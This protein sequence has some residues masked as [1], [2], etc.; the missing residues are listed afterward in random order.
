MTRKAMMA[1]AVMVLAAVLTVPGTARASRAL[2]LVVVIDDSGSMRKTDPDNIRL[3]A[4]KLL[5]RLLGPEDAVGLVVFDERAVAPVAVTP[6][7]RGAPDAFDRHIDALRADGRFTDIQAGL[8][9]AYALLAALPG[10]PERTRG[11]LLMTDGKID[12][13]DAERDAASRDTVLGSLAE[14]L[15]AQE[16]SVYGLAFTDESDVDLI[17]AVSRRTGGI[18]AL[19]R[20]PE[21]LEDVFLSFFDRLKLPDTVP[22]YENRFVLDSRVEEATVIA[23]K[24]GPEVKVGLLG[25]DGGELPE[26]AFVRFSGNQYDL[27][28]I[29]KP[30]PGE[31]TI[32]YSS[33]ENN[34]VV[35]LTDLQIGYEPN[36]KR[37][38]VGAT[39]DVDIQLRDGDKIVEDPAALQEVV[40]TV[41]IV[42]SEGNGKGKHQLFLADK[43]GPGIW[44]DRLAFDRPGDYRVRIDL[45]ALTFKRRLEI[46]VHIDELWFTARIDRKKDTLVAV[47]EEALPH[48]EV[49]L[50]AAEG[51]L[52]VHGT[53]TL[54]P[55][56]NNTFSAHYEGALP[57]T[58]DLTVALKLPGPGRPVGLRF[59]GLVIGGSGGGAVEAGWGRTIAVFA[60]VNLV[61]ALG[62]GAVFR[63]RKRRRGRAEEEGPEIE[64]EQE[65][66][67]D[68]SEQGLS[69]E[70]AETSA[71][72]ST[73]ESVG[74]GPAEQEQ[75]PDDEPV[76]LERAEENDSADE[77]DEPD[78]S[79][80]KEIPIEE[81][82]PVREAS[83]APDTQTVE[84]TADEDAE[85]LD[86]TIEALLSG[87]DDGDEGNEEPGPGSA[88]ET[89]PSID[90]DIDSI[91]DE[92][93]GENTGDGD[94]SATTVEKKAPMP[95]DP[96]S[97]N[98]LPGDTV[99]SPSGE[100][101]P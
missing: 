45:T 66:I 27:I 48:P 23:H 58:A 18:S 44:T 67:A 13:G 10:R 47:I 22:V 68:E 59:P 57:D 38:P 76:L 46:P 54:N 69:E 88:T 53:I 93:F 2:D 19:A 5:L 34:R 78:S 71:S 16:T 95:G 85:S 77:T 87:R 64:P 4:A 62:A 50:S 8:E 35:L 39:A 84:D 12:T 31:W 90:R 6:L 51:D 30:K 29:P 101:T 97:E 89:E 55:A 56:G 100:P 86:E 9:K 73:E 14:R 28:T 7:G 17:E 20:S 99:D 15:A 41:E 60:G 24:S 96:A 63:V 32:Q 1:M 79:E 37:L 21:E 26:K 40:T 33:G 91:V 25:P 65:V 3:T 42:D 70:T 81:D 43:N 11:V 94:T 80:L 74:N 36:I 61:F 92:L 98:R 83:D 75:T 52:G 72:P 82:V 49:L